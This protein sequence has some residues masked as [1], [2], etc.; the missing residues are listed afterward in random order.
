MYGGNFD[1]PRHSFFKRRSPLGINIIFITMPTRTGLYAFPSFG[2]TMPIKTMDSR[3]SAGNSA[4]AGSRYHHGGDL[5]LCS[6]QLVENRLPDDAKAETHRLFGAYLI[7]PP[8][9]AVGNWFTG[10]RQ[11]KNSAKINAVRLLSP[12]RRGVNRLEA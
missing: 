11:V 8:A 6:E 10:N 7:H 12:V 3:P 4:T 1:N 5:G 9:A 2:I